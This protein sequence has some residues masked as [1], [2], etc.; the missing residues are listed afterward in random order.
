MEML[1]AVILAAFWLFGAAAGVLIVGAFTTM[2]VT[3]YGLEVPLWLRSRDV[4]TIHRHRRAM[5]A[6]RRR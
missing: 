3:K 6:L 4:Q 2:I 5:D 1:A